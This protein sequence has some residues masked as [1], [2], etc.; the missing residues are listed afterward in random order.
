[1]SKKT[2]DQIPEIHPW[3]D[4]DRA[5]VPLICYETSDP[6]QTITT[7]RKTMN[8]AEEQTPVLQWDTLRG[9]TGIN[10]LG[11]ALAREWQVDPMNSGEC[12]GALDLIREKA[13]GKESAKTCSRGENRHGA[14]FFFH[15]AHRFIDDAR[16]MQGVWNLRDTFEPIG[17]KLVLLATVG[18]VPIELR[19]DVVTLTDPLPTR[20][21]ISKLIGHIAR[22]AAK[23]GAQIDADAI[24]ADEVIADTL[25]GISG[26]GVRQTFAMSVRKAG[27]DPENLWDR[28]RKLIEQTRGLKMSR[29]K[30]GFES[31][32]GLDRLKAD[33]TDL[34]TSEKTP[35][36]AIY[37]W[38]EIEKMFAGAAGDTSGT[39]QDQVGVVLKVMQ[40]EGLPGIILA[41]P[42]GTGKTE[43]GKGAGGVANAPVIAFDFGACKGSLVGESEQTV[44]AMM[45]VAQAVSG[46]KA[47]VIATCNSMSVLPPEL[48]RRFKLGTY[49]V[50]L[51]SSKEQAA[52]W[53]VWL[54]RFDL[55]KQPLPNCENWT[56]AEISACC[57]IAYRTG[58]TLIQA[59]ANIVPVAKSGA[60][61]IAALRK[62]ADGVFLSANHGGV[63]SMNDNT[64]GEQASGR[65][66]KFD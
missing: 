65:S 12:G 16:V 25:T 11:I 62:M 39:S 5:G 48:R 13:T 3:R 29:P 45:Q 53:P 17:A 41:G 46:G 10:E 8:G 20:A 15:N 4:V 63:Y 51:P 6:K 49:Y 64:S 33:L 31:I 21:E 55:D 57:E 66:M 40:D 52:I 32:G 56:G 44:R 26:F 28:K 19:N 43:I 1:M 60:A 61:Q 9:I 37:F 7:V 14:V 24:E 27:V 34:L 35:V 42:A 54:K 22:D 23:N 18:K 50:D 36:R 38:D 59:A 58:R 30:T 2:K 47:L